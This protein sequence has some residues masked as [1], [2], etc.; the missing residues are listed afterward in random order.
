MQRTSVRSLLLLCALVM[1]GGCSRER[2]AHNLP[3]NE[4][5]EKA[6][7]ALRRGDHE[8]SKRLLHAAAGISV[9]QNDP[10]RRAEISLLLGEVYCAEATFDSALL[11][12]T[13]ARDWYHRTADKAG[14]RAAVIATAELHRIRGDFREA[15]AVLMDELRVEEALRD[16]AG[17]RQLKGAL[18]PIVRGLADSETEQRLFKEL[19]DEYTNLR[20]AGMM[21]RVQKEAGLSA[22]HRSNPT[23]AVQYF[24][25]ALPLAQQA[26][27]TLLAIEL[28]RNAAIAYDRMERTPDAFAMFTE[29]LRRTD[30]IRGAEDL[31]EDMLLRVGNIYLR[32]KQWADARRFFNAALRAAI[33]SQ[34]T[35]VEGYALLQLAQCQSEAGTGEA[36]TSYNAAAAL[37]AEMGVPRGLAYA[38]TCLG[39]YAQKAGRLNEALEFFTRAVASSDSSFAPREDDVYLD[40]E[41]TLF[42]PL[43]PTPYEFL[44]D[45]LM[46][47][48][49]TESALLAAE[50]STRSV[51]LRDFGRI[52]IRTRDEAFTNA[53]S[54]YARSLGDCIGAERQLAA[55]FARRTG[56]LSRSVQRSLTLARERMQHR[57]DSLAAVNPQLRVALRQEAPTIAGIQQSVP[58]GAALVLYVPTMRSL[59]TILLTSTGWYDQLS[60]IDK[61]SLRRMMRAYL[62]AL[63]QA[64]TE[65]DGRAADAVQSRIADLAS[66]LHAAFIRPLELMAPNISRL[67]VVMPMELPLIPLHAL[68]PEGRGAAFAIQRFTFHYLPYAGALSLR[69]RRSGSPPVVVGFGNSGTTQVDAEYEVRDAKAFFKDAKLYFNRD[70]SLTLLQSARGDILHAAFELHYRPHDPGTSFFVLNDGTGYASAHYYGLRELF[71]LGPY[72]TVVL[73]NLGDEDISPILPAILLMNGSSEVITNA[74][75]P[76]RK[77]K[78]FFN[79]R[80][81]TSLAAGASTETAYR[82]ALLGMIQTSEYAPPN[83]WGG[84]F[85]W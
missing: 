66:R 47:I 4:A 80:F 51:L 75:L 17:I 45:L 3:P 64:N 11:M 48:G 18:L 19:H 33:A 6:K 70:A 39:V 20:D 40:C 74:Y 81:Y 30:M 10:T 62:D 56:T 43:Q 7:D 16:V 68:R 21:A 38:Q 50:Q 2:G 5:F 67:F 76:P 9:Q 78:K 77:A 36:A 69:G 63:R 61:P 65:T 83:V 8:E 23:D 22:L 13:A 15:Y 84:F 31:R 27:D 60:A 44:N 85:L 25:D 37:F 12:Y 1:A 53:L 14:V 28:Y 42:S 52:G 46:Q 73:S 35:L 58:Q 49:K 32:R 41:S 24:L 59:H 57:G 72:A 29:G 79:E 71:S 26:R 55:A 34:H 82:T 54:R